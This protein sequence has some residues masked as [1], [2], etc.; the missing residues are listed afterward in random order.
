M[1]IV[2]TQMLCPLMAAST[3]I[4]ARMPAKSTTSALILF[5]KSPSNR[6]TFRQNTGATPAPRSTFVTRSGGD[7]YHGSVFEFI[8]NDKLD[9]RNPA[10]GALKGPLRFN[11]FGWDV[12]GPK[13]RGKLFF[14]A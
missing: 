11:D 10:P 3:W 6:R 2:R 13:K 14:F 12:G 9:A 5:V 8:R 7:S 1:V 4:Q